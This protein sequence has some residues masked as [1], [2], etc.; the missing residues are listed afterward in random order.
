M[1]NSD[2]GKILL[3]IRHSKNYR[4]GDWGAFMKIRDCVL[5]SFIHTLGLRPREACWLRFDDFDMKNLTL[6]IRGESNKQR[7]DRILP[8]P[9]KIIKLLKVYLSLNRAR[10]WRGS[11]YLFPSLWNEKMSSSRLK[12]RFREILKEA[13]MYKIIGYRKNNQPIPKFRLYDL[14]HTFGSNIYNKTKDIFLVANL[15]GHSKLS[16]TSRYI[17]ADTEYIGYEREILNSMQN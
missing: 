9:E 12:A 16:S 7:K 2:V 5:I 17:H 3:T 11:Q 14:R 1:E 15:L 6:K 13:K 4:N 10:F 8:I